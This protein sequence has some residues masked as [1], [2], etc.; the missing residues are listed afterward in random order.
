[1]K[2]NQQLF[3]TTA[4]GK[5]RDG[6]ARRR[7]EPQTQVVVSWEGYE[8]EPGILMTSAHIQETQTLRVHIPRGHIGWGWREVLMRGGSQ[9]QIC[10]NRN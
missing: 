10:K 8:T 4:D 7:K 1:M 6:R 3:Q 5:L 9:T 2:V